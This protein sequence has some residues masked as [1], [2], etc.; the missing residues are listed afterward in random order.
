MQEH[1]AVIESLNKQTDE[2]EVQTII[3][4]DYFKKPQMNS[5]KQMSKQMSGDSSQKLSSRNIGDISSKGS[6][7]G[8]GGTIRKPN[9]KPLRTDD[10]DNQMS[11]PGSGL[12]RR[13]GAPNSGSNSSRRNTGRSQNENPGSR[14]EDKSFKPE[15]SI[16][17]NPDEEVA[18]GRSSALKQ[19]DAMKINTNEPDLNDEVHRSQS[20]T[21]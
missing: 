17:E 12:P 9:K 21:H 14:D 3:G 6:R 15:S 8:G 18:A 16:I 1:Q 11:L 13:T 10:S 7:I 20:A 4:E 19:N 5:Q 2:K